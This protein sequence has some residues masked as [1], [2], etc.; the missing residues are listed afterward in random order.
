MAVIRIRANVCLRLVRKRLADIKFIS[1]SFCLA[2]LQAPWYCYNFNSHTMI[3]IST[4][5]LD[6][7]RL[8][9][10]I[11]SLKKLERISEKF[12]L[13]LYGKVKAHCRKTEEIKLGREYNLLMHFV[14]FMKETYPQ[15]Q[16]AKRD[17]YFREYILP[18]FEEIF[19]KYVGTTVKVVV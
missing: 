7:L 3:T 16:R 19:T 13:S 14:K 11:H 9:K 1:A 2:A 8:I 12:F 15:D 17:Y 10:Q 4:F 18:D 5:D 6:T